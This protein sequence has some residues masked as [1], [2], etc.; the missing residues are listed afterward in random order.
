M[1]AKVKVGKK[2]M[3]IKQSIDNPVKILKT[4]G[5]TMVAESQAAFK[6][7]SFGGKSW[8]PRSKVNT[9]GIIKDFAQNKA[10]P[11]SRRFETRP[12]L[13]DTGL[14]AK[15]IAYNISSK[16][17][18]KV[19]TA[20]PYGSVQNF[21]GVTKSE[22]ITKVM[23]TK[24]SKWL[25]KQSKS[26]KAALSFLLGKKL[27]GKSVEQKVRARRFIGLTAKTKSALIKIVGVSISE[28]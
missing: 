26:I 6:L 27:T 4:I 10:K 2:L 7:Q 12:A 17:S 9:F 16:N 8:P 20:L 13:M 1:R 24:I 5:I 15:S 21:G 18:V 25:S 11:P 3:D 19:G 23:Q 28:A 22:R 14:L